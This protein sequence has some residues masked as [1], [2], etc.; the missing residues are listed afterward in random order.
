MAKLNTHEEVCAERWQQ[1]R[2]SM[3]ALWWVVMV[4]AG[5][6]ITGMATIIFTS[7]LHK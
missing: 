4:S 2:K 6:L 3:D 7:L 5:A 1:L